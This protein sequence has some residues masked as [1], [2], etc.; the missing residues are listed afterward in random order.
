MSTVQIEETSPQAEI[1]IDPDLPK[2]APVSPASEVGQTSGQGSKWWLASG[3][4]LF[5]LALYVL[6]SPGRIDIVDGQ[7]RFDVTYNW[8]VIGRPIVRDQLIAPFMSVPGRHAFR[9]SYYGAPASIFAMPLV[10]LGLLTSAPAIQPS[11]F[12]FSLTSSIIGAGI[13]PIL[14]LFYLELGLTRR[15]AFAWTMVSSFA[16]FIWPASNTTFDNGQHAFFALAAVYL[17][18]LGARRKSATYAAFGGLM[19]GVLVLYQEYFLLIIPALALSTLAWK[20]EDSSFAPAPAARPE[21]IVWRV[22]SHLKQTFQAPLTLVRAAW[23][24]PGEARSSCVRYCLF[25]AGVSVGVVLSFAYNDLRFGSYLENG[26]MRSITAN[27]YPLFGNPLAGFLTLL[28]SPGKSI[29]LYSPPIVLG[30]L[31]MRSFWRRHPETAV[32]IILASLSL[33]LFLSCICFVGGDWCWGPRY[34]AVLVPLWALAFPFVSFNR[35]RRELVIAIVA[36]GL[37][38]QVMA[39]S[40]ENQRFFLERGFQDYFWA[41]DPW[42]YFKYSALF[43][44]VGEAVSLSED[45]PPNAQFF[46]SLPIP[47]WTTYTILGPPRY[48]P[49]YLAPSWIR[50]YQIYFIPRPWPLWMSYLPPR[51]RPVNLDAWLVGLLSLAML[52]T[53]FICRGFQ[54]RECQ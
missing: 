53:G 21:A 22:V 43:A 3:I 10:W 28:V 29:F 50:N 26:K 39:L 18:F 31:G 23:D 7:A 38:V 19:A 12:L 1:G 2:P 42:V 47:E 27:A 25:L 17:G 48:V 14:F 9:Y 11:Q 51:L 37:L 8:L 30:I 36:L 5:V 4:F 24:R 35:I 45:V 32:A 15:R 41:E 16:T 34:L 44:R 6:T 52:G 49:R 20:L 40:V 54:K 33:V 13:A 46:N